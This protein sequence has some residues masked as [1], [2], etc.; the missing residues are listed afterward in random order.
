MRTPRPCCWRVSGAVPDVTRGDE[1]G[2]RRHR[3]G[4]AGCVA[5]G[6]LS[7]AERR[8]VVASG[9]NAARSRLVIAGPYP[10]MPHRPRPA[11]PQGVPRHHHRQQHGGRQR[12]HHHRLPGGARLGPCHRLGKP[13]R[14][15]ARA[16]ARPLR[17]PRNRPGV[18]GNGRR[19]H[20]LI[21]IPS[22]PATSPEHRRPATDKV[23][24]RFSA[25][26]RRRARPAPAI[27]SCSASRAR[28]V[29]P[30]SVNLG[31]EPEPDN[32]RAAHGASSAIAARADSAGRF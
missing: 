22:R 28:P 24:R 2:I 5:C 8:S 16:P 4:S 6:R 3:S 20:R 10:S 15:G 14:P 25:R 32:L 21:A 18:A 27:R 30:R 17:Q 26:R 1:R 23:P 19:N 31:Y 7:A 9:S 12:S 29:M 11:V 13:R